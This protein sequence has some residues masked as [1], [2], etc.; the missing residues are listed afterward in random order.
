MKTDI[1]FKLTFS[2][3]MRVPWAEGCRERF[4]S[5][6]VAVPPCGSPVQLATGQGGFKL[7]PPR[8]RPGAGLLQHHPR[9]EG[10]A[11]ANIREAARRLGEYPD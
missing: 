8:V 5:R 9:A 11:D 2:A 6:L 1:S 7:S 10:P 3:D 4:F